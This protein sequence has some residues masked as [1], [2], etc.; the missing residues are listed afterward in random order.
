R[1]ILRDFGVGQAQRIGCAGWKHFDGPLLPGGPLALDVPA[2]LADLLRELTGDPK[3]VV[4]ANRL[5]MDV[6]DGLRVFN[7]PAQI[8]QFE[9]ASGVTSEGVLSL[10]RH[11]RPG[12]AECEL[13]KF[14]DT[15]GLPLSC[16][17]MISFGD[18]ARRGLSSPSAQRAKR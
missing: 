11:L 10:L 12:L 18:K 8:A 7:E 9:Y 6:C 16:H 15:R 2:Y 4:N 17:R 13:E 14:L 3:C 5:F 1:Q